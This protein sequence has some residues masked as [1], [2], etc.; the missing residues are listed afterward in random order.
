M[1]YWTADRWVATAVF[2]LAVKTV[3]G[4]AALMVD[5]LAALMVAYWDA[6]QVAELAASKVECGVV[7]L[8][9][10]VVVWSDELMGYEP[11]GNLVS[12]PVVMTAAR[13]D[14]SAV[15][16]MAGMMAAKWVAL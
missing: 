1:E 7:G 11:V 4:S 5:L 12:L 16:V 10:F 13:K 6:S 8:D 14:D 2:L 15:A 3:F 9:A